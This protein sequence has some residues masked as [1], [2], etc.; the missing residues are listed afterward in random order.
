MCIVRACL[1]HRHIHLETILLYSCILV[2]CS[3]NELDFILQSILDTAREC[4][5]VSFVILCDLMCEVRRSVRP[6]AL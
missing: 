6:D 2:L 5:D 1:H 3:N 4:T